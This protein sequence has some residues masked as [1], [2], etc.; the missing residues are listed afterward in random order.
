MEI[1]LKRVLKNSSPYG[2]NSHSSLVYICTSKSGFI[3]GYP[4]CMND[5]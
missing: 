2:C 5:C 3:R 1:G 4:H